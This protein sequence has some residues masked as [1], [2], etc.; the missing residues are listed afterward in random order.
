MYAPAAASTAPLHAP[1]P[2]PAYE[3]PLL[4]QSLHDDGAARTS[5]PPPYQDFKMPLHDQLLFEGYDLELVK[6]AEEIYGD[7]EEKV[8][9]F[10]C[11]YQNILPLGFPPQD[12]KQALLL[13]SLH[14]DKAISYLSLFS[15]LVKRGE[16]TVQRILSALDLFNDNIDKA[17]Q[18]IVGESQLQQMG[19]P[20]AVAREAL[21]MTD[22]R[23]NDALRYIRQNGRV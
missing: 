3:A 13:F 10:I 21:V 6:M 14:E 22:C 23:V 4:F 17:H 16:C 18:Y 11:S 5:P 8:R 12:I 19:V 9:T 20:L 1:S 2:L 7:D 15:N